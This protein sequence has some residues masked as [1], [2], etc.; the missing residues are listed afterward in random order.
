MRSA[1]TTASSQP[2]ITC[3]H[4]NRDPLPAGRAATRHLPDRTW[5][6]ADD[7]GLLFRVYTGIPRRAKRDR[8]ERVLA[9]MAVRYRA[10]LPVVVP[11]H[12]YATPCTRVLRTASS[13]SVVCTNSYA[14]WLPCHCVIQRGASDVASLQRS[15]SITT[16]TL[17]RLPARVTVVEAGFCLRTVCNFRKERCVM[18]CSWFSYF[19]LSVPTLFA[20]LPSCLFVCWIS[21]DYQAKHDLNLWPDKTGLRSG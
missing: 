11:F 4:A 7:Q 1:H 3:V 14:A 20:F 18:C 15:R 13:I 16:T 17:C 9:A 10:T 2:V 21:I 19:F 8:R 6:T 5:F 12:L